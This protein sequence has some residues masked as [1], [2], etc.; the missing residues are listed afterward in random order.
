MFARKRTCSSRPSSERRDSKGEL[1][2]GEL[3]WADDAPAK[4]V[5]GYEGDAERVDEAHAQA[6]VV[7]AVVALVRLCH[8]EVD[9]FD[10]SVPGAVSSDLNLDT[11]NTKLGVVCVA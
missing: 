7:C 3:V 6:Y 11:Q 10:S 5:L 1:A 2:C 9:A 4:L 8:D